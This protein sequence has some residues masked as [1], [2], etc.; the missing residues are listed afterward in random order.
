MTDMDALRA[1]LDRYVEAWR[2]YD[3]ERIGSLFTDDATYRYRP[4]DEPLVGR[5]AIVASWLESPDEPGSWRMQCEPLAVNGD[6]AVARCLTTYAATADAPESLYSN[7]WV[8]RLTD[9]G[10]ASDF[11]EWW[12]QPRQPQP[13]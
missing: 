12:M 13:G 6:L 2:T 11:T 9:D 10:R 5:E 1:W 7:I 4:F 3:P 8:L